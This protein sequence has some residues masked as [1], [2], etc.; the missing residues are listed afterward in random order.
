MI[1]KGY[2]AIIVDYGMAFDL[3]NPLVYDEYSLFIKNFPE[4]VIGVV[5]VT[6]VIKED[7]LSSIQYF[8]YI[9]DNITARPIALVINMVHGSEEV[10]KEAEKSN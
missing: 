10:E 7:I 9:I 1:S 3:H 2:D 5:V 8:K 4:Y 6:D